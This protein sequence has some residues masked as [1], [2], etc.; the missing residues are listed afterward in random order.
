MSIDHF[1]RI[2]R[3]TTLQ[4]LAAVTAWSAAPGRTLAETIAFQ[5]TPKGYGTDPDLQSPV[6]PW[7]RTMT[8]HQLQ[9]TAALADLILPAS[10]TAQA[11]SAVGVPDFVDEWVSAPYPQ[12]QADRQILFK[13]L[14]WLDKEAAVRWR[15]PFLTVDEQHKLQI[16]DEISSSKTPSREHTFFRRLRFLVIGAYYTTPEGFKDIGYIGNVPQP[17]YPPPTQQEIGIL[18]R[19][20]QK[21]GIPASTSNEF[22]HASGR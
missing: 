18:E 13:G 10:A 21:L 5:P 7:G 20:L 4:W 3:R 6:V 11:P 8:A 12:Q 16:L 17:S 15:N 1:S 19:E 9:M 2:D 14:A 22:G